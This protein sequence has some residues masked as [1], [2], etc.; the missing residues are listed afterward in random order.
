M[1]EDSKKLYLGN[2]I[3]HLNDIEHI[4]LRVS[5]YLGTIGPIGLYKLDRE[6]IQNAVDEAME[7]YGDICK[8]TLRSSENLMIVE[9]WGRGI[10]LDKLK[11]GSILTIATITN[12]ISAILS[13]LAP[14]LL[15][16]LVLLAT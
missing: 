11:T 7:G 5:M 3:K 16:L 2:A 13:N 14:T 4:R 1:S 12:I 9:D 10:P 8:V 15:V 6:P